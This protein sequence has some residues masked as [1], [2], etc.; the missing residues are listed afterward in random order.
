MLRIKD[1]IEIEGP[2]GRRMVIVKKAVISPL[3]DRWQVKIGDGPDMDVQGNTFDDQY[4]ISD[5][6]PRV[7]EASKWWFRV[8]DLYCAEIQQGANEVVV[9]AT[10]VAI[11]AMSHPGK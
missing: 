11:D 6:R 10:T 3:H 1:S 8:R 2:S 9:L 4:S 5:V 7:A